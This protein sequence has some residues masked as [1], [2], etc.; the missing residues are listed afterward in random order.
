LLSSASVQVGSLGFA[1]NRHS[2]REKIPIPFCGPS[3]Q[4][5]RNSCGGF[6]SHA[7]ALR[8]SSYGWRL[9]RGTSAGN[10]PPPPLPPVARPP[11]AGLL[12]P[13]PVHRHHLLSSCTLK[14][15]C[16]MTYCARHPASASCYK[17][18]A[19]GDCDNTS[20]PSR[21]LTQGTRSSCS[22]RAALEEMLAEDRRHPTAQD[23]RHPASA[24]PPA[25]ELQAEQGAPGPKPRLL[26]SQQGS[27]TPLGE[28]Q[29]TPFFFFTLGGDLFTSREGTVMGQSRVA[30]TTAAFA[31]PARQILEDIACLD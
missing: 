25:A 30:R 16:D 4:L 17:E 9:A 15:S 10:Q 24:S 8:G 3:H 27:Q 31:A 11:H 20:H 26:R 22:L 21:A 13:T 5:P 28:L 2:H 23:R 14:R 7:S 18:T 19:L 29:V 6:S 12:L 1:G